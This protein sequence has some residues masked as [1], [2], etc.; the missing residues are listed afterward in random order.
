MSARSTRHNQREQH[1]GAD[2][3]AVTYYSPHSRL[4]DHREQHTGALAVTLTS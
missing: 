3:A 2:R 4:D 1:L